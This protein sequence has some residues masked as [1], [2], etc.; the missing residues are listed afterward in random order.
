MLGVCIQLHAVLDGC[1]VSLAYPSVELIQRYTDNADTLV[2]E[3]L[4]DTYVRDP[5]CAEYVYTSY[6]LLH[7]T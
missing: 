6:S 1:C 2:P 5:V 4:T 3:C 7:I